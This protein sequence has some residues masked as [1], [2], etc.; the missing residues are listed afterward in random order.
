MLQLL[1]SRS[2]GSVVT[3]A[4]H[5]TGF[6]QAGKFAESRAALGAKRDILTAPIC[7]YQQCWHANL[8]RPMGVL[9]MEADDAETFLRML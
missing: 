3:I 9:Y 7:Q 6:F 4:N 8:L 1:D 2:V 5:A